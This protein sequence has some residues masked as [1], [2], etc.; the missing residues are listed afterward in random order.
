[1]EFKI[2]VD[3]LQGIISRLSNV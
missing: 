1:M 3:E 2:P